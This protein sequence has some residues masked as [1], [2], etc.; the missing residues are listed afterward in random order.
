METAVTKAVADTVASLEDL[1]PTDEVYL[2]A[3]QEILARLARVV[4]QPVHESKE[5]E[6]SRA[7]AAFGGLAVSML[8]ARSWIARCLRYQ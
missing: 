7:A 2:K 3:R 1:S 4:L 8:S 6:A 5:Q